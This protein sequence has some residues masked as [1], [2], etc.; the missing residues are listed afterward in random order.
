MQCSIPNSTAYQNTCSK[1]RP[2][3]RAKPPLHGAQGHAMQHTQQHGVPA[4]VLYKAAPRA[5]RKAAPTRGAGACSAACPSARR[6]STR[7]LQSG[8]P[9]AAQSRP[10]T[11]RRDMQCGMPDS[12]AYLYA[13]SIK[14][15]PARRAKPPLHGA[16]G[17]A[18]VPFGTITNAPPQ[19]SCQCVV[20]CIL[21]VSLGLRSYSRNPETRYASINGVSGLLASTS[22]LASRRS[23]CQREAK[24]FGVGL[25]IRAATLFRQRIA[26]C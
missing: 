26:V 7:A 23:A 10:Y 9:R 24:G 16:H 21:R 25:P 8:A 22:T 13:C 6:S 5:P 2:A 1:R 14:R 12:T 19:L 11:G 15:R 20:E 17:H 4:S 3:R 18:T